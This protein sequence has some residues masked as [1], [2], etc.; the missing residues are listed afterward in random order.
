MTWICDVCADR[1]EENMKIRDSE[2]ATDCQQECTLHIIVPVYEM[3]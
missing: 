2:I 3:E 1:C